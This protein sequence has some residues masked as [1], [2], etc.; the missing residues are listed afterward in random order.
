MELLRTYQLSLMLYMSGTCGILAFMTVM[1]DSMPRG[2]KSVLALME[3]SAMLLLLFDRASYLYRGDTSDLGFVMVRLS[4]GMV[5]FLSVFIPQLVTQYLKVLYGS[6]DAYRDHPPALKFCDVL[7]VLG[8]VLIIVSQFTGLYYTFDAQ[9]VYHR[10]PGYAFSYLVPLLMV[11]LQEISILSNRSRMDRGMVVSLSV[12][13]GLPTLMAVVQVFFYG[14]S[15][16]NITLVLVVIVFHIYALKDLNKSVTQARENELA[17]YKE[18]ERVK[19]ALF[20]Q[21]AEALASA[22]DAKDKYTHGH[23]TRV[24]E[25]SEQIAREAGLSEELCS[26]VFFAALLHDVGKIGV[27]DDIINKVGAL[28]DEEFAQIRTHPILG[29][30]ILSS[31]RQSPTLRVGAHYHHERYDGR[32]YPDGLAGEEIP[33]IARIVAVADAYDAMTSTRSYR[34]QLPAKMVRDELAR[35]MG[36]QFDP[37]FAEI[38]LH[39]IDRGGV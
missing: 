31:I 1:T 9:N 16:T 21:T 18:A 17:S 7:F 20:E 15:L 33:M 24:A 34:G 36:K 14:V 4:N 22:I 38:L 27:R 25:L 23:S 37:E 13:I 19:T 26:Q 5:F 3:V 39:I 29:D 8:T 11:V 6:G 2:K 32:G 28:T 12:F 10:A 30:Q 35:G